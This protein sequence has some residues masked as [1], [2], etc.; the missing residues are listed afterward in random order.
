MRGI[1]PEGILKNTLAFGED[2]ETKGDDARPKQR[3]PA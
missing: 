1:R 2:V 3:E